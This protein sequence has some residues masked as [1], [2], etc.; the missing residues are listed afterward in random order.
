MNTRHWLSNWKNTLLNSRRRS[1]RSKAIRPQASEVLEQKLLL[2]ALNELAAIQGVMYNDLSENGLTGD[3]IRLGNETVH[4][5]L[6]GGNGTFESSD[7]VAGG[8][9]TFVAST[10]TDAVTGAYSF[11]DLVAGVYHVEQDSGLAGYIHRPNADFATVTITAG[12]A[13]GAAGITIDDFS[14]PV[15]AQVVTANTGSPTTF[16]SELVAAVGGERDMFVERTGGALAIDFA[17]N[18]VPG[19]LT[20]G[21]GS[22]VT[23]YGIVSW[24]GVDGAAALNTTGMSLDLTNGGQSTGIMLSRGGDF[25]GTLTLTVHSGANSSTLTTTVPAVLPA[26]DSI[27]LN[28][29]DFVGT[30]D[31]TNV[32]AIELRIEGPA[33]FDGELDLFET[34]GPTVF[35]ADFVNFV[36]MTL[37]G[38]VFRDI[39]NSGT[40]NLPTDTGI[41]LVDVTL[42]EDTNGNGTFDAVGDTQL[43]VTQTSGGGNYSFGNLFPGEY[44][45]RIDAGNF[46]AA[47]ALDGL[48]TSTGNDPAPDPDNDVDSDDNGA[49]SGSAVVTQAITLVNFGEPTTDGDADSNTNFTADFAFFSTVDIQVLKSDSADPIV[50]GSGLGNLV[51]TVT[52]TNN[53]PSDATGVVVSDPLLTSLPTGWSLVSATG[54]GITS[55]NSGT[56]AWNIGSLPNGASETLTVTIT[57]GASA[58]ATTTTNTATVTA[59][60]ETDS[61]PG[62]D[63]ASEDTTV[64]RSVDIQVLKSDSVDPVEAGSGAGN[65]VYT[66][67]AT[68]NGPSDATGVAVGDALLTSLPTGWSLVTAVGSGTTTFSSGTGTWNIGNLANGASETLTVTITVGA[69][70]A[71]TTTTNTAVVTAVNETDS[72]PLNNSDSED[73]TVNRSVDIALNKSD[74][75]DPVTAGSGTGNLVYTI[76]ATNNGPADASGVAVGDALLTSLPTG[77]SLVTAVGSGTTTFSSGTGTWNIG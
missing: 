33:A 17:A 61:N 67:T 54:S 15:A 28:F 50:A 68:N 40:R 38:T 41:D 44:I 49:V 36:P 74:N 3:D 72:N 9:D 19:T 35:T 20:I 47:A 51:Y 2:T 55:F 45:V 43:A 32:G 66:V 46:A 71:A 14:D 60:N 23:G 42:F 39:N 57:V 65:L 62:N 29:A 8:D 73:T 13:L 63:S 22:G 12:D 26:H 34:Y 10:T 6:D 48:N 58:A 5:Y 76:M 52:A 70:A 31:F 21:S 7:G 11:V 1:R 4:L 77:W 30:A 69:S 18:A 37:G 75:I 56:G 25:A 53:G 64:T 24:D 16:S 59:V 27:F